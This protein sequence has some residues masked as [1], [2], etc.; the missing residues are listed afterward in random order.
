MVSTADV[1]GRTTAACKLSARTETGRTAIRPSTPIPPYAGRSRRQGRNGCLGARSNLADRPDATR[2]LGKTTHVLP[3]PRSIPPIRPGRSM[4]GIMSKRLE[5]GHASEESSPSAGSARC[6]GHGLVHP[7]DSRPARRGRPEMACRGRRRHRPRAGSPDRAAAGP[8]RS[9]SPEPAMDHGPRCAR[10][11][12]TGRDG[13]CAG[14]RRP[15]HGAGRPRPSGL[16]LGLD[17][18]RPRRRASPHRRPSSH[19]RSPRLPARPAAALD[20]AG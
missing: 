3:G 10:F 2:R 1:A 17:S 8:D 18:R 4:R 13:Q 20:G 9:R 12:G 6:H 5:P 11:L 14:P 19:R 16:E 7:R 15:R